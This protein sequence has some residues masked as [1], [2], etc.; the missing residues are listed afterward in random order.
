V[1]MDAHDPE[2]AIR[3]AWEDRDF[4]T[5]A[6][7]SLELYGAEIYSFINARVRSLSDADEAYSLF[8]EDLWK[9][10]PGF[11]FR[12]TVR[13]WLYALARNAANRHVASPQR[14][15]GRN[16]PLSFDG[17]VDALINRSRSETQTHQ[18]TEVKDR[19]RALRERLPIEDQTLLILFVDRNLPWREIVLIMHDGEKPLDE[20]EL[21]R[22]SARLRKRF[23]RVKSDLKAMAV[24]EGLLEP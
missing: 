19:M 4:H 20:R 10:L 5:A 13:G 3:S 14:R 21:G 22:E 8:S 1:S 7:L 15:A 6:T 18:R 12:S 24:A 17:A 23:E 9:G 16:L 2:A 11:A